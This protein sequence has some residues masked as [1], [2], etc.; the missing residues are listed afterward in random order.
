[1]GSQFALRKEDKTKT[2]RETHGIAAENGEEDGRGW[3]LHRL[4]VEEVTYDHPKDEVAEHA[5]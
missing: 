2:R 4:R 5:R 3:L 1:V